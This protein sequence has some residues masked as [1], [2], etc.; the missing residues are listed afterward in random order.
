MDE[1]M[2]HSAG[3]NEDYERI[4]EQCRKLARAKI[5]EIMTMNEPFFGTEQG[6]AM[7][8]EQMYGVVL[9]MLSYVQTNM[10]LSRKEKQR[11]G[12]EAAKAAGVK[13]GRKQKYNAKDHIETIR[14]L[15]NK[16]INTKQALD[17]IGVCKTTLVKMKKELRENNLI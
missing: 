16:E 17:E 7:I 10:I 15:E 3:G 5:S 1:K 8:E 6:R 4:M 12:I 14:K 13:L 9:Q 11:R 2:H